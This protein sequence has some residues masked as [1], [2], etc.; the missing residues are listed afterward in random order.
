VLDNKD[1]ML[2]PGLFGRLRLLGSV[3]YDGVLVPAEAVGTDQ[4]RRVVYVVGAD[5]AISLAPVRLGP[6]IDGY[7]VIREGLKGDETIVVNGLSRVRPGIKID[8]QMSTLPPT[9]VVDVNP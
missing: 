8:P 9:R 7:R 4:N 5:S 3:T 6:I 2:V 1:G